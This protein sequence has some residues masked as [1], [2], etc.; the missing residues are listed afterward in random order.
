MTS[1]VIFIAGLD[2]THDL[3]SV[4][5]HIMVDGIEQISFSDE[6]LPTETFVE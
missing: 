5:P 1:A 6:L 2:S 3:Q 4:S